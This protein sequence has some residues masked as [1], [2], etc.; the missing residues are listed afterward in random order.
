MREMPYSVW[1]RGKIGP[2]LTGSQRSNL[3]YVLENV[4][5]PSATLAPSFRMSTIALADGR[6]INGIVL[7]KTEQNWEVQTA[8]ENNNWNP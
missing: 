2:D 5:D 4:I 1:D 7:A 3:D 8:T 6:V